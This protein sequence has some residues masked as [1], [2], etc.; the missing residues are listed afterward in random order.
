MRRSIA[1]PF[2]DTLRCLCLLLLVA[3]EP[4]RAAFGFDDVSRRAQELAGKPHQPPESSLPAA[5]REISYDDYRAIRFR[6]ERSLWRG[7]GLPFEVQFF[8]PGFLFQHTVQVNLVTASGVKPYP[9]DPGAFR[10]GKVALDAK[11]LRK[12]GYA[13]FRI[14]FPI[15]QTNYKD[16][17]AVFLGASYFRGVGR[18]QQYGLS[19]RGL[20]VDTALP[21]G[22]EVPSFRE[23]W[24]E[25]P[26]PGANE[27]VVYALLDSRRVTGA[28]RF[29]IRPGAATTMDV[30]ARLFL[31]E[32]V[33]KL[34]IAPLSSMYF[35]GENQ[36]PPAEDY[37]PEVHDS[38]GLL[39]AGGNGEWLWRPL[40]NPR[41]LLVTSFAQRNPKGFGLLQ[42]D[43]AFARYEDLEARYDVRPSAWIEP[44]GDWGPGRVELVQIP[45]A[46]EFN[47]NIV[48]YW[49]PEHL[50][51]PGAPLDVA[52]RLHWQMESQAAPP[53][54][55]VVQTRRAALDQDTMRFVI[56]FDGPV[57]ARLAPTAALE[58]VTWCGASGAL[59]AQQA[60]PN[61]AAGG[62]R[63]V[64]TVRR[65][66]REEPVELRTF[67]RGPKGTLTETWSYVWPPA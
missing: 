22:E 63:V 27:L 10:Y 55:H 25:W 57:L 44:Q 47:D 5:L 42:R 58:A 31:R 39:V 62:W 38:D 37:R 11:A 17:V 4:A 36:A 6:P 67:L 18:R 7:T 24:I 50:P 48:A 14:H 21:S 60:F 52:Y 20:A 53:D 15:N 61:P 12:L 29:V 64:L 32:P 16:E 51:A 30:K 3:S 23:F 46:D 35:F 1:L 33:G 66:E 28:Y 59:V 19:A 43:R 8:H 13:G 41:R 54:A 65:A 56:D 49:V 9:F 26:G 2:G 34:G 40:V 45:T